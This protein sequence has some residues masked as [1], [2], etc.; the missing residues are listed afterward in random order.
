MAE[1]SDFVGVVTPTLIYVGVS[2][3]EEFDKILLPALDHGE[4]D[5]GNHV[6]S[7]SIKQGETQVIFQHWVKF[8][9]RPTSAAS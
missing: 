3:R 6:I 8:R 2:S 4:N 7:K 9:I 1:H 5:K